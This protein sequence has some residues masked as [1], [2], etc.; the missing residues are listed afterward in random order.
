MP[1]DTE[2]D[3]RLSGIHTKWTVIRNAHA[4][5]D[6]ESSRAQAELAQR[7]LGAIYRYILGAVR[8]PHVADDLAQVFA[9][10]LLEGRFSGASPERGRFRDFIRRSVR[11]LIN[12]HFRKPGTPTAPE[13][14]PEPAAPPEEAPDDFDQRW[15]EELFD[16]TWVALAQSERESGQPYYTVL[17]RKSENPELRAA[18]IAEQLTRETGKPV[19]EAG[20]RKTVQRAREKFASLLL[21]EVGRSLQ[22]SDLAVIEQELID[23]GLYEYCKDEVQRRR[24]G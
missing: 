2:F 5:G 14:F 1:D 20:V 3:Q 11:N 24:G 18:Q 17:K 13:D 22:S 10:R 12:D 16:R 15:R 4:G 7:Y 23:L 8:D 9:V 19:N 6:A 21:D